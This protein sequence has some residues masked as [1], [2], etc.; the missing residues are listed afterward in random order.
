MTLLE[1]WDYRFIS[2]SSQCQLGLYL[3]GKLPPSFS[4]LVYTLIGFAW[5]VFGLVFLDFALFHRLV[6]RQCRSTV[7]PGRALCALIVGHCL[8][9]AT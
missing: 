8:A 5:P 2:Q 7:P 9:V 4:H 3:S 6:C 1:G